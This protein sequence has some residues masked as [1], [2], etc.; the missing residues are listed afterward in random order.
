MSGK[1]IKTNVDKAGG[2]IR[3]ATSPGVFINGQPIGLK[4]DP[5]DPH[6]SGSHNGATMATG[7][8]TVF[9]NGIPVLRGGIDVATCGHVAEGSDEVYIG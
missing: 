6:G 5:V 8:D 7:S 9:V 2:I 1:A 4:G 3:S